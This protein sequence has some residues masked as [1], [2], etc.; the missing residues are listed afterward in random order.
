[1]MVYL[2]FFL[3]VRAF[4]KSPWLIAAAIGASLWS[5]WSGNISPAVICAGYFFAGGAAALCL[6]S[7]RFR[8]RPELARSLAILIVIAGL[9]IA[10][11]GI[12]SGSEDWVATWLMIVTPPLLFLC[13][14]EHRALDRWDKP[15]RAAGNLT[16]S[17]YL[18][19]FPIQLA[20]ASLALASGTAVPVGQAW[21]L[22]AY[23]AV[24]IIVGRIV[25]LRFEAPVQRWIRTVTL[26]PRRERAA[27]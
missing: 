19:H 8:R 5:M 18:L 11:L 9:L 21:F 2:A 26:T 4:G 7:N 23:L 22:I 13:A 15:I 17:T 25:F 16:Y 12:L 27:A 14:Q 6:R 1:V 24:T 3:L 20:V 10:L